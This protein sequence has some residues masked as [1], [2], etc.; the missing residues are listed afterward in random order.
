MIGCAGFKPMKDSPKGIVST[1]LV[2]TTRSLSQ[3]VLM[4]AE[5]RRPRCLRLA[6]S[7]VAG[8]RARHDI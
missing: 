1:L 2:W 8:R 3:S 7:C 4:T 5:S 6:V